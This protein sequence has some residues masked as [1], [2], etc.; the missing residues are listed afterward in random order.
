MHADPPARSPIASR[1]QAIVAIAAVA[2]AGCA[3]MA[4][5][6]ASDFDRGSAAA[7]KLSKDADSCAKQAEAHT[8]QYGY[9]PYD[10]THG[11]YNYMYDSCMQAN[12]YERKQP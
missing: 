3:S 6:T 5:H 7:E 1:R 11:A 9:G 12:G 2:I 4:A 10:P 8:K